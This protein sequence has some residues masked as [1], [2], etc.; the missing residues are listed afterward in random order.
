MSMQGKIVAITGANAGLGK[1]TAL[2][3]AKQGAHIVMFCRNAQKA[4]TARQEIIRQTGNSHIE[5]IPCD[6]ADLASVRR[7][8]AEFKRNHTQLHVLVNNAGFMT[9]E[10]QTSHNGLEATFAVNYLA[11]VLL[12]LLL[13]DILKASAPA[14]IINLTSRVHKMA[15]LD[16]DDL[17][18]ENTPYKGFTAYANSKLASILFTYHLAKQLEGS[19]VT[20]NAVDPGMVD[21]EFGDKVGIPAGMRIFTFFLRP[22]VKQP[23]EGALTSIKLASDPSLASTTGT[24]WTKEKPAKS[25][26]VSHDT[27]LQT[28]LQAKAL[29]L[30]KSCLN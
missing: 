6:L 3:L 4:E 18:M 28:R 9:L 26:P 17:M 25:S 15:K 10:Q 24:F 2:A 29:V 8:A 20:V 1:E 22:W 27:T 19:G 12:T 13:L 7:A 30:L 21:T 16:L 11:H 14:R 23:P 5:I